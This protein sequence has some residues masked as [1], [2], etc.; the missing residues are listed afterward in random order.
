V[1]RKNEPDLRLYSSPISVPPTRPTVF[2]DGDEYVIARRYVQTYNPNQ[3]M[4]VRL[5]WTTQLAFTGLIKIIKPYQ[6]ATSHGTFSNYT[7]RNEPSVDLSYNN[8]NLEEVL[9]STK[10]AKF[11]FMDDAESDVRVAIG[12]TKKSDNPLYKDFHLTTPGYNDPLAR[13]LLYATATPTI[14][15][16]FPEVMERIVERVLSPD[17]E[18]Q[19]I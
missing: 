19:S 12:L 13:Q 14:R 9:Q 5:S 6:K 1:A 3:P 2:R 18:G 16:N 17:S 4:S 8:R 15:K 10:I 7:N 11:H